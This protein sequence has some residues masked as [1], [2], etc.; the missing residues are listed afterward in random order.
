MKLCQYERNK[1][2][3]TGRDTPIPRLSRFIEM[4]KRL[5]ESFELKMAAVSGESVNV[6]Q[7]DL[8]N[9]FNLLPSV[10]EI[11]QIIKEKYD[12]QEMTKKV[13]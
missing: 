9:E 11:I 13:I 4:A 6:G 1:T 12:A 2:K 5:G 10:F 8:M 7:V 3:K